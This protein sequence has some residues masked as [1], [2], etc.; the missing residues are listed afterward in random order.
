MFEKFIS[1]AESVKKFE[2]SFEPSSEKYGSSE[3]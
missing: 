3:L 1:L 2:E